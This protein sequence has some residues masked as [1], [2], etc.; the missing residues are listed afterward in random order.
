MFSIIR[1]FLAIASICWIVLFI[2]DSLFPG[3]VGDLLHSLLPGTNILV[4]AVPT[5]A[6]ELLVNFLLLSGVW[7]NCRPCLIPWLVISS[8]FFFCLSAML[9]YHLHPLLVLGVTSD[10][11]KEAALKDIQSFLMV[12]TFNMIV[13]LQ[14]INIGGVLKVFVDMGYKRDVSFTKG[15]NKDP[16]ASIF[17]EKKRISGVY[18]EPTSELEKLKNPN[19]MV[20]LEEEGSKRNSYETRDTVMFTFDEENFA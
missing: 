4:L 3:P 7:S 9:V 13:I 17:E 11:D 12:I 18:G 10:N 15:F 14:M 8:I 16:K 6:T 2:P 20:T 1:I 5:L 19:V